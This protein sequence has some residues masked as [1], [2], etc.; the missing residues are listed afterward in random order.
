VVCCERLLAHNGLEQAPCI[1][2]T[3]RPAVRRCETYP[4]IGVCAVTR[5]A[6]F[7]SADLVY[8]WRSDRGG[9]MRAG[10]YR[11]CGSDNGHTREHTRWKKH[12]RGEIIGHESLIRARLGLF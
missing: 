6:L 9:R 3:I 5:V 8:R 7:E 4:Q 11:E 1:R 2:K 12:G 10:I